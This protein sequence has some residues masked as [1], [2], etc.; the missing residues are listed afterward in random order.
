MGF[1]AVDVETANYEPASICQAGVV[2]FDDRGPTRRWE[3]LVDPEDF[4][5][6]VHIA[7]Q[8]GVGRGCAD[9]SRDLRDRMSVSW[10]AANGVENSAPPKI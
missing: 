2:H 9:V 3:S 8:R 5:D 10:R 4:F 1:A 6:P 7:A